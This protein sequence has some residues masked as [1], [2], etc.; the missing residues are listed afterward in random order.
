MKRTN[1]FKL[2]SLFVVM[3]ALF[4]AGCASDDEPNDKVSVSDA[5]IT[6]PYLDLTG[7]WLIE[8]IKDSESGKSVN[9]NKVITINRFEPIQSSNDVVSLLGNNLQSWAHTYDDLVIYS[10]DDEEK[11]TFAII[12][13]AKDID[14][15][16]NTSTVSSISF[17]LATKES[18]RLLI[19][20][21]V[22]SQLKIFDNKMIANTGAFGHTFDGSVT[23]YS[24][25]IT[26]KKL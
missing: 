20:S 17:T 15:A 18:D 3:S 13:F 2:I 21:F 4:L 19:E 1:Y 25:P 6:V 23:S 8:G 9:I 14:K 10:S 16:L 5:F 22:L 24:G 7:Q 26:L 11:S 12:S